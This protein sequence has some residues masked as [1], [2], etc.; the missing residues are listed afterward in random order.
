MHIKQTN[1]VIEETLQKLELF[2][3]PLFVF[4]EKAHRYTYDGKPYTSVTQFISRFHKPFD[5]DYWAK[6]KAEEE[7]VSVETI[8]ERWAEINRRANEIGTATHLWAENYFNGIWTPLTNDMDI[9]DRINKFNII[10]ATHL[11]HLNPVAFENRVFSKRWPIAGTMDALFEYKGSLFIFD[12]KTNKKF[13]T[14]NPYNELLLEPFEDLQKTHLNEYS[15][16]ISLYSLILREVGIDIKGGRLVY[17]GP[18]GP[19]EIHRCLMME[20]RLEAYLDKLYAEQ[21]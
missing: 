6:K 21:N 18:E 10:Y 15:I 19:A 20:D 1:A 9:I 8:L 14:T 7:G 17:I 4:D 13:T 16:Q 11:H 3:D 12:Y 5:S 2:K